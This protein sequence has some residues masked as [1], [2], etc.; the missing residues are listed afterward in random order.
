MRTFDNVVE[1]LKAML[2]FADAEMEYFLG[3]FN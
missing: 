3:S 1:F 2:S